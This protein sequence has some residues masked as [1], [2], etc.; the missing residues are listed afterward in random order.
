MQRLLPRNTKLRPA[1]PATR[2]PTVVV[3]A[4]K[5]DDYQGWKELAE[6]AGARLEMSRALKTPCGSV[7]PLRWGCG[8]STLICRGCRAS[9]YAACSAREGTALTSTSLLKTTRQPLNRNTVAPRC[10]A[11]KGATIPGLT[12]GSAA[13][14]RLTQERPLLNS[15]RNKPIERSLEL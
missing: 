3:V 11:A 5:A 10:S 8:S 1:Q 13:E 4:P 7:A 2:I 9:S 14:L 6:A 12:V 15:N